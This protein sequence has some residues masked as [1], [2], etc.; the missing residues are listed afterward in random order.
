LPHTCTHAYK[1][2]R[3]SDRI[4]INYCKFWF[5]ID[6]AATIPYDLLAMAMGF[7][8]GGLQTTVLAF[9]KMPRLLKLGR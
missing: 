9:L 5:P 4:A 3:D 6:L 7:G 2:V 8:K 1:Q